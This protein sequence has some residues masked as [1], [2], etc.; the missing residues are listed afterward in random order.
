MEIE[1][2]FKALSFVPAEK[3]GL[4]IGFFFVSIGKRE[5]KE[6]FE[7][8]AIPKSACRLISF[9][10]HSFRVSVDKK[11]SPNGFNRE[12]IFSFFCIKTKGQGI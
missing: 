6:N 7:T 1:L 5:D 4:T 11:F 3:I 12:L 8:L 10:Y 2:F 9:A